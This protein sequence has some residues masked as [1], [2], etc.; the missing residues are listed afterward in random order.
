[1]TQELEIMSNLLKFYLEE[2]SP[3]LSG[4]MVR[5]IL[6]TEIIK[7]N[8]HEVMFV[9]DAPFYD[10]KKWREKGVIVHTG[11]VIENVTD[12]AQSVNDE[13]G[14]GSHNES[15]HWVNRVCNFVASLVPNAEIDN[16][17]E[18]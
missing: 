16:K 15:M 9:I 13:G 3:V 6:N 2:Y 11:D 14:F 18:L 17:L 5:E 7:I 8:D 1:M 12:Y 4:N 10:M